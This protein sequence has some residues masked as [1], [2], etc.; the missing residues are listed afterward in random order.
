LYLKLF[1]VTS[2]LEDAKQF[3]I[4]KYDLAP[5]FI[6]EVLK[7]G[8]DACENDEWGNLWR[9]QHFEQKTDSIWEQV[10]EKRNNKKIKS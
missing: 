9:L 6:D 1:V 10:P 3:L 2:V 4:D 7:N 8:D 5:D